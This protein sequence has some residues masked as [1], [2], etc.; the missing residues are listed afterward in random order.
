MRAMIC[1][2]H[3]AI[4]LCRCAWLS[5]GVGGAGAG[6]LPLDAPPPC[7]CA[8]RAVCGLAAGALATSGRSI[9]RGDCASAFGLG[10]GGALSVMLGASG[11][12]SG[13]AAV[14]ARGMER[15]G[16]A[17]SRLGINGCATICGAGRAA[18]LIIGWGG[19]AQRLAKAAMLSG[20]AASVIRSTPAW[21]CACGPPVL[22]PNPAITPAWTA[23]DRP[24]KAMISAIR[25]MGAP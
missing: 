10:G 3:V 22:S 12:A 8:T 13:R 19:A 14:G 21:P 7:P 25:L 5:V 15:A 2:P 17:C 4:R 9:G 11:D 6:A 16:A 23:A 24:R 18:G 1:P 20:A